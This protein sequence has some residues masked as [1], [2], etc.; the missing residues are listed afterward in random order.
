MFDMDQPTRKRKLSD[1]DRCPICLDTRPEIMSDCQ[2][3]YCMSC[4]KRLMETSD[5]CALCRKKPLIKGYNELI[6]KSTPYTEADLSCIKRTK[7]VPEVVVS[8]LE[9]GDHKGLVLIRHSFER[10]DIRVISGSVLYYIAVRKEN[11]ESLKMFID[12]IAKLCSEDIPNLGMLYNK[13]LHA[14]ASEGNTAAVSYII[15]SSCAKKL[16]TLRGSSYLAALMGGHLTTAEIL[17][18]QSSMNMDTE[19]VYKLLKEGNK[20]SVQFFFKHANVKT[21]SNCIDQLVKD[22]EVSIIN[23]LL[24]L[25]IKEAMGCV[26]MDDVYLPLHIAL[27]LKDDSMV[28]KMIANCQYDPYVFG[29]FEISDDLF[30]CVKKNQKILYYVK[31]RAKSLDDI[32]MKNKLV[33]SVSNPTEYI[34]YFQN[35]DFDLIYRTIRQYRCAELTKYAIRTFIEDD[36][37]MRLLLD[38][39][40]EN[41]LS[42]LRYIA[43]SLPHKLNHC[44]QRLEFDVEEKI[45]IKEDD[46]T[47]LKIL[48][49]FVRTK[50]YNLRRFYTDEQLIKM[51]EDACFYLPV[52]YSA[53]VQLIMETISPNSNCEKFNYYRLYI[54]GKFNHALL[55][56]KDSRFTEKVMKITDLKELIAA[57]DGL[58]K[59]FIE[60]FNA[61]M[62]MKY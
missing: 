22:N 57:E 7:D 55:L 12:K 28:K 23:R 10:M 42:C 32:R 39:D 50:N 31:Q 36:G 61:V 26:H 45:P 58:I 48:E 37:K 25:E 41:R 33:R 53:F 52:E 15:S 44:M 54:R 19:D 59:E 40:V 2:H 27:F 60:F 3:G 47:D 8:V 38:G 21:Y 56:L 43:S 30:E 1:E 18:D 17:I 62:K 46:E 20:S 34:I 14:S 29:L 35:D 11:L 13:A 49:L 6:G 9:N 24:E 51:L 5:R 4:I 16:M